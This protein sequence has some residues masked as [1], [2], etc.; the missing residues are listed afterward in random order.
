MEWTDQWLIGGVVTVVA[1]FAMILIGSWLLRA[2]AR[3]STRT[4]RPRPRPLEPLKEPEVRRHSTSLLSWF[5]L[6]AAS[7]IGAALLLFAAVHA[8]L[9]SGMI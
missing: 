1:F 2:T 9:T 5:L 7:A 6:L 8:L 4:G 3:A